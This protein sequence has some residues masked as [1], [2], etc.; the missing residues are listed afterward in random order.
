MPKASDLLTIIH[1]AIDSVRPSLLFPAILQRPEEDVASWLS[2]PQ[3]FLLTLGKASIDSAATILSQVRCDDSFVLAPMGDYHSPD[4]HDGLKQVHYGSHPVPDERSYQATLALVEWLEKLPSGGSLLVVLSGGTSALCMLPLHSVS[5]ESKFKTNELLIRSGASIREINT[6]RKHLS[7]VK[8]GRLLSY[9]RSVTTRVLVI[10]DVTGDDLSSI[11]SGPFYP[12]PTTFADAR[13][14][15]A[16]HGLWDQVPEDVRN[17]IE[18]G[19]AG[20]MQETPKP[21]EAA[22]IPHRIVASNRI[23][24]RVAAERAGLLGYSVQEQNEMLQCD[25]ATAA[26][27][28]WSEMRSC[29][30]RTAFLWGGEITI[31]VMGDGTG[32]RNQ[33]LALLMAEKIRGRNVLFGSVGTDGIDGNSPA[34][35]AWVDGA[36]FEKASGMESFQQAVRNCDSYHYFKSLQQDITTGPTGTNVMDLYLALT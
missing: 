19:M 33:H 16:Q 1:A 34:A 15:L 20:S 12:D 31:R 3:R 27:M 11:G 24:R 5:L 18:A 4:T 35:G 14:V 10:S 28:I 30:Q 25:V 8:G 9:L 21:G 22:V 2:A 26:E 13:M 29:A 23:A 17:T 6:V 7:S 36:S 32:G